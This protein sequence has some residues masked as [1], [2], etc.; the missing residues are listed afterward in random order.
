MHLGKRTKIRVRTALSTYT[1]DLFIPST[2][3]RVSDLFNDEAVFFITLTDV[4]IDGKEQADF[5]ALNKN[6]VESVTQLD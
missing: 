6:M 4:T 2:R 1:G 5:V 3:N